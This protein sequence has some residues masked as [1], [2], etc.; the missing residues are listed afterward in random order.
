[1]NESIILAALAG[2][3]LGFA[4]SSVLGV[5]TLRQQR[6]QIAALRR[7]TACSERTR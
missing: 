1:M 5:R 4:L 3:A 7:R 2:L 6:Q